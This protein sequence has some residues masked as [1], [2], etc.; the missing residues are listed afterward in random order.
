MPSSKGNILQFNQYLKSDEMAYINYYDLKSLIEKID[1]C[2]NN[3]KKSSRT[4]I[5]EHIP[6][7]Y[8]MSTIWAFDSVENKRILYRGEFYTV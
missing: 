5:G 6:S 4:K 7:T 3:P 1:G 2:A 8:S